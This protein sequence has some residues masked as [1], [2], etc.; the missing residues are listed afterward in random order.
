MGSAGAAGPSRRII[1]ITEPVARAIAGRRWFPLWAVVHHRGR[2]SGTEYATPIAVVPS[3]E[4]GTLLI[5]LP[6]GARTN[7][8]MNVVAAGGAR[9][10]WKGREHAFTAP[11]IVQAAEAAD[12]ARPAF[13]SVVAR[14]PAAIVLSRV[15]DPRS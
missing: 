1:R 4:P 2:S 14:M 13:R 6:W 9:L 7:W 5:G 10:T 15:D 8:A 11:R 3:V 12:L